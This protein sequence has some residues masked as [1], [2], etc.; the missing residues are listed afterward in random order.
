MLVLL[1]QLAATVPT[2]LHAQ[3]SACSVPRE[4]VDVPA[5]FDSGRVFVLWLLRGKQEVSF[6]TDTGGGMISLFP[7]TIDRLRMS[8]GFDYSPAAEEK[9]GARLAKVPRAHGDP[10]FPPIPTRDSTANFF[11][12]QGAGVVERA[13]GPRWDGLL[14]AFWFFNKSWT[15]DYARGRLL[16]HD[17]DVPGDLPADCWVPIGF[18][19]DPTGRKTNIFPRIAADIDGE[20]LQFLLDTGARTELTDAAFQAIGDDWHRQ[21]A[22]SFISQEVFDR[23]RRAHPDWRFVEGAEMG[24]DASPMIEVPTVK[25]GNRRLGPVWFTHRPDSSFAQF[26]S[27]YTDLPVVGALGG[28]AWK[29]GVLVLDYPRS[30]AAF[31]PGGEPFR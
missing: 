23:W 6:Y 5:R 20:T 22:T 27:G 12:V 26:M 18:Q 7:H 16:Y 30:R 24:A 1:L 21:R 17:R 8:S 19:Q 15:I 14:G 31:L 28:T 2:V 4:G 25:I 3:A 29:Y 13:G 11:L 10:R 9:N